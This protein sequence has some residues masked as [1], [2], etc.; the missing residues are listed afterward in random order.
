MS[1]R[2]D[3]APTARATGGPLGPRFGCQSLAGL[4]FGCFIAAVNSRHE[5]PLRGLTFEVTRDRRVGAG[6]AGHMIGLGA[7][8]AW[9]QAVG[10][11]VD[12]RVRPRDLRNAAMAD[13][14]TV[15]GIQHWDAHLTDWH[16]DL[17]LLLDELRLSADDATFGRALQCADFVRLSL[18]LPE[19]G[20]H[21][22]RLLDRDAEPG[23]HT[24]PARPNV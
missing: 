7:T 16:L 23:A 22:F 4:V 11:R 5:L 18:V 20:C 9:C 17:W 10:P 12:R 6:P 1:N 2:A 13:A 21:G 24:S 8:R 15:D 19:H 3:H 14:S